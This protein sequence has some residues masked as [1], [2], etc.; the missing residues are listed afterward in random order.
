M[1][2]ASQLTVRVWVPDVWD[3]VQLSVTADWTVARLK[4]TALAQATG[5]ELDLAAYEVKFRGA[6]ILDETVTL[7][8]IETPDQAPFIVLPAR[9]EPVR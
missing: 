4:A 5:R 8:A 6:S 1:I 7:A 9:R 2:V 3:I